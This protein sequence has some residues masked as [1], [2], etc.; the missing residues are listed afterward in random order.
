MA[1]VWNGDN[2]SRETANTEVVNFLTNNWDWAGGTEYLSNWNLFYIN[3]SKTIGIGW[4]P[5][6]TGLRSSKIAIYY[7]GSWYHTTEFASPSSYKIEVGFTQMVISFKSGTTQLSAS[8]CNKIIICNG[9]DFVNNKEEQIVIWLGSQASSNVYS[10]Y[11]SD[12]V[13]PTDLS[14]QNSNNN[15]N[16]LT[17][18]LIPFW[19]TKTAFVTTD[20]FQSVC[21]N[22]PTWF[23]SNIILNETEYRMSG[24]VFFVDQ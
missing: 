9:K 17:T 14:A 12:L 7:N 8:D 1:I 2:L 5:G 6:Y 10:M 11:T 3:T 19:S 22:I 20:V 23:F 21:T 15:V 18:N 24:S 4:E 13:I 16:S